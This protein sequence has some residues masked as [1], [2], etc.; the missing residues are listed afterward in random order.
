MTRFSLLAAS[1]FAGGLSASATTAT[2]ESSPL[3]TTG[4]PDPESVR[5]IPELAWHAWRADIQDPKDCVIICW[6]QLVFRKHVAHDVGKPHG[7]NERQGGSHEKP[8]DGT[9][10]DEH[11]VCR[12]PSGTE[13]PEGEDPVRHAIDD[14]IRTGDVRRLRTVLDQGDGVSAYIAWERSAIQI[15]DCSESGE[16]IAHIPIPRDLLTALEE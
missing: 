16:L 3:V 6:D 7:V 1:G 9:C 2:G 14:A 8:Y 11:P 15:L 4:I 5:D 13:D 10:K 12:K